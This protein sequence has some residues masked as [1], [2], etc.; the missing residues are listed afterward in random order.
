LA[1]DHETIMSGQQGSTSGRGTRG[2][3]GK[4][5]GPNLP[6]T[7]RIA[8]PDDEDFQIEAVVAELARCSAVRYK[9]LRRGYAKL[10]GFTLK[11]LDELVRDARRGGDRDA[12]E[13][14]PIVLWEPEP[15]PQAVDGVELFD[16]IA[17]VI[18]TY[19]VLPIATIRVIALW[20]GFTYL[21]DVADHAPKLLVKS[22]EKRSG[23]TRLL[24]L[25]SYLVPR[26]KLSSNITPAAMFRL[27]TA[28]R[29]TLLIDE[30]DSFVGRN[31]ELRNHHQQRVRPRQCAGHAHGQQ[32]Q[33]R[34]RHRR[35][36]DLVSAG[37]GRDRRS[38]RHDP[39]PF[40]NG[41]DG[42]QAEEPDAVAI[43]GTQ[44]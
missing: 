16:A 11:E 15:W 32:W 44:W 20:I 12:G 17:A 1:H 42:S 43:A 36:F 26:P 6:P 41:D 5:D 18:M 24:Q 10:F 7:G 29:P 13:G 3:N 21:F 2:G 23:K 34:A 30:T 8:D 40:G 27:I 25:I 37:V 14:M 35:F 22:V 9:R 39:G 31:E 33:G 4:S 19:L 38:R 28:H